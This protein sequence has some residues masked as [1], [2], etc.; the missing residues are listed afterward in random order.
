MFIMSRDNREMEEEKERKET[1][2]NAEYYYE[3]KFIS[4]F[5]DWSSLRQL[6]IGYS[7]YTGSES[8]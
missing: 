3:F 8:I 1:Y 5:G 7:Y 2:S 4:A 6:A